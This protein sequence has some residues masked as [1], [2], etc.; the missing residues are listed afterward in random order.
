MELGPLGDCG[1][2]GAET[3]FGVESGIG[4]E[5]V[6]IPV[7][8]LIPGGIRWL[9]SPG[10]LP[11]DGEL[12]VEAGDEE[13]VLLAGAGLTGVWDALSAT[14]GGN[15]GSAGD[16]AGVDGEVVGEADV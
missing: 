11:P 3:G 14:P 5:G 8:V 9:M 4:D 12:G 16:A 10:K 15:W 7:W 1:V 13:N 6:G 2:V